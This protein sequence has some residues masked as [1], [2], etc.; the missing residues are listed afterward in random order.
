MKPNRAN[1]NAK[2]LCTV[3]QQLTARAL[4]ES[5]SVKI[6][7]HLSATH[8]KSLQKFWS[9]GCIN[10][11]WVCFSDKNLVMLIQ[12]CNIWETSIPFYSI[13]VSKPSF[14]LAPT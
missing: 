11:N 6:K 3:T 9:Y 1:F 12:G 10:I 2:I 7:V 5:P 14:R 4:P 8:I 13:K